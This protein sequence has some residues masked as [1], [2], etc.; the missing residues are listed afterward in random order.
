MN[1]WEYG[2]QIEYG[3]NIVGGV[4]Q[5]R[6]TFSF[7][8]IF[9]HIQRSQSV[10]LIKRLDTCIFMCKDMTAGN[11]Q[12]CLILDISGKIEF[13]LNVLFLE[14]HRTDIFPWLRY[15]SPTADL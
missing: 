2:L 14:M 13:Y 3:I 11:G 1:E 5:H 15:L 6:E 4:R 7:I 8:R 12:I 10:K 9:T